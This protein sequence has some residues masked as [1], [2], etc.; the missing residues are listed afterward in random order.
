MDDPGRKLTQPEQ[1][2]RAIR[3]P[4]ILAVAAAT[5]TLSACAAQ[6]ISEDDQITISLLG[7]NDVHGQLLPEGDRGGLVA[8]SAYVNALRAARDDDGG[9][10]LV[11]DAGDMWQ[12]TLESNLVEGAAIVDAFNAIGFD[13][14]AIGNHEFDFG[15]VGVRAVPEEAGDDPRGALKLGASRANFPLL[16]ANLIDVETGR[17]V[18]WPN[19]SPSI[20]LD[21]GGV[22][23]GVIGVMTS[24]AL[25]ATIAANTRGLRVAPLAETIISEATALRNK[26]ASIVIVTA[27]AG[28]SCKKFDI[29]RI[30]RPATWKARSCRLPKRYREAWSTTYS[31]AIRIKESRTSSTAFR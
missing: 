22:R 5:L 7:T 3:R 1:T 2:R 21:I 14:A 29:P 11:I 13:A 19:V 16:A 20:I 26:G 25:Q 27:H 10:V 18:E 12:G 23:V 6:R 28:S 30:C 31:P 17:P 8:I 15:P 9:A 4:A 24:R